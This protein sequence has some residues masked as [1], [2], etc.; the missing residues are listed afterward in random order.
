MSALAAMIAAD[1]GTIGDVLR[2]N[3]HRIGAV[4]ARVDELFR[5]QVG[6]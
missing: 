2:E 5:R 1:Y 6:Q 3:L 4:D